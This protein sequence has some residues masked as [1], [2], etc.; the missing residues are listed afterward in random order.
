M[1]R[2]KHL[3]DRLV[4]CQPV[5][6]AE[7]EKLRGSWQTLMPEANALCLEIGCGKGRFINKTAVQNPN[8]LYIAI[9]REAGALVMAMEKTLAF[10]IKN[11]F[12]IRTDAENLAA[13]FS[14]NEVDSIFINFCDPWP[15]NKHVRRRLTHRNF[16]GIYKQII[17]PGGMLYFK[18]DNA[19]LFA[20][21][22]SELPAFGLRLQN[23]THDLHSTD[24]PNIMTEYEERF[25]SQGIKINRLE[26]CFPA[27][28]SSTDIDA[29]PSSQTVQNDEN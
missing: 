20:F 28:E 5:T 17:K 22:L 25:S 24:T 1:R 29:R 6:I 9:E 2:K 7:P 11:V 18:T 16:L 10:G 14:S 13:C 8:N 3:Q 12:Y 19:P 15:S 23:V 21:S 27:D 26:A 4:R